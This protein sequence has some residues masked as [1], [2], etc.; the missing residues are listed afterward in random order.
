ML[1]KC[2]EDG[3]LVKIVN[4]DKKGWFNHRSQ[5]RLKKKFLDI[6]PKFVI[7]PDIISYL[8]RMDGIS[9][10]VNPGECF[11]YLGKKKDFVKK[12]DYQDF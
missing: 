8:M 3:M 5:E 7:G 9:S 11:I 10:F 4:P 6:P 2:L 12:R 1:C